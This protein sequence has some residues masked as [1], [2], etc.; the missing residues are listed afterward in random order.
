MMISLLF[1]LSSS[2][3]PIPVKPHPPLPL[4]SEKRYHDEELSAF[5]HWGMDTCNGVEVGTGKED[6]D[7]FDSTD[8]DTDNIVRVLKD[9]GFKSVILV[10]KHHDG[11]CM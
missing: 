3:E 8:F 2:Y 10:A 4:P 1:A 7:Q 5:I 11:F 6:P 9:T